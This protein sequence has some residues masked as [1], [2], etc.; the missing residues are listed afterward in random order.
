MYL[1][2]YFINYLLYILITVS[3]HMHAQAHED[4][5]KVLATLK[6]IFTG[7]YESPSIGDGN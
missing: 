7:G 6:T 5:K 3:P 4:Q 2:E 1:I